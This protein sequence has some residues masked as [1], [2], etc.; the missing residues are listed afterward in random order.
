[1]ASGAYFMIVRKYNKQYT[2]DELEAMRDAWLNERVD[3]AGNKDINSIARWE[4]IALDNGLNG[5]VDTVTGKTYLEIARF[6]FNSSIGPIAES[7]GVSAYP[8]SSSASELSRGA[9]SGLGEAI[10]YLLS[11]DYSTTFEEVMRNPFIEGI[12]GCYGPY[13]EWKMG[14]PPRRYDT[15]SRYERCMLQRVNL[16]LET[17]SELV[18]DDIINETEHK[19][20]IVSWG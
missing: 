4:H 5:M 3:W 6:D 7:L 19:L 14:N 18:E 15:D 1:M 16:A 20:L 8:V 13:L 10:R 17:F 9:I 12:D 11:E 2:R